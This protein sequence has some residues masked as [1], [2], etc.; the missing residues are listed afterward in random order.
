MILIFFTFRERNSHNFASLIFSSSCT[1]HRSI[2][3]TNRKRKSSNLYRY[4]I[5]FPLPNII[6]A[7]ESNTHNL[8]KKKGERRLEIRGDGLRQAVPLDLHVG[9]AGRHSW[10]HP[11]GADPLRR[12]GTNW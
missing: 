6:A 4:K 3:S 12:P 10:D 8:Q 2:L 9:G 5:R 1:K 11:T 7:V